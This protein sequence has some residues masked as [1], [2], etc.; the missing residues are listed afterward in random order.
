MRKIAVLML[1]VAFMVTAS[2]SLAKDVFAKELKMAYVDLVKVI[3][4]YKKT[5]EHEKTLE[6]KG[7]A[8][9]ADRK[10]I[11]DEI[12][13]LKDEQALLSD[14]AKAEKQT[15]IDEKV[16]NLQ[17]FD[18]KTQEEFMKEMGDMRQGIK[19]DIDKIVADYAKEGGYD[20]ILNAFPS[21]LYGAPQFDVT[22]EILKRL[23][24]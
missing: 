9:E 15:L 11:V 16:K 21:V 2:F 23:N 14:K 4:E 20:L 1:L 7:K 12:R 17:A 10:K 19:Q 8:K 6:A 18:R 5:K 24:K 3:N 13:K 22:E